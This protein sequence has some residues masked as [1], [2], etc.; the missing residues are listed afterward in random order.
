MTIDMAT[1]GVE[2]RA[3]EDPYIGYLDGSLLY[4]AADVESLPLPDDL[5]PDTASH[6]LIGERFADRV[7]GTGGFF[8][9]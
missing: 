6:R 1:G 3:A 9:R 5:H 8:S 7:F 4:G 2:Q